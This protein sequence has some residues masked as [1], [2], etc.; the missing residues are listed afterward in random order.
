MVIVGIIS[1]VVVNAQ[2]TAKEKA[3]KLDTAMNGGFF[4]W[5]TDEDVIFNVLESADAM[6]PIARVAEP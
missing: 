1:I 6:R 2:E 4:G 3:Q 5:G